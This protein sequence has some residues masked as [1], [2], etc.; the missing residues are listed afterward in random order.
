MCVHALPAEDGAAAGGQGGGIVH[1]GKEVALPAGLIVH[2]GGLPESITEAV[3]QHAV[4]W[5]AVS[6]SPACSPPHATWCS[7]NSMLSKNV[8]SMQLNSKILNKS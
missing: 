3:Q 8:S 2:N 6:S 1:H 4:G 7:F 5:Q